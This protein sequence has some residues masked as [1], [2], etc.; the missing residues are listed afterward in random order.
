MKESFLPKITETKP[1]LSREKVEENLQRAIDTGRL[2][3][4]AYWETVKEDSVEHYIEPKKE[5]RISPIGPDEV[6]DPER[7]LAEIK[8]AP[9]EE[10]KQKL[11]EFK[12]KLAYQKE[13]LAR[14][15]EE[16][17][18]TIRENPD[19]IW[20]ELYGKALDLLIKYGADTEEN[21]LKTE[22]VLARYWWR[23]KHIKE[24][25]EQFPDENLLFEAVFGQLPRGK[26]EIMEGPITLYFRC[27]NLKD[28]ALISKQ[29]FLKN[30]GPSFSER[31]S[32]KAEGGVSISTSLVPDLQGTI[33]A[34][35]ARSKFNDNQKKI[36][37]HEEQHA[38]K[39]L[40][41]ERP[42]REMTSYKTGGSLVE[43]LR[44]GRELLAELSVKDEIL[45]YM[46]EG[47]WDANDVF[48]ILTKS[49]KKGGLY[50]Y[51][52][53][54]KSEIMAIHSKGKSRDEKKELIKTV[55]QIFETEYYK[56]IKDGIRSFQDLTDNGYTKEQTIALLNVEPLSKWSKVVKRLTKKQAI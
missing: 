33:I 18:N 52:T 1:Q 31:K 34:E 56:L 12:E 11:Q 37:T 46:K 16:L 40:F 17:T 3:E 30:R 22:K 48:N 55:K 27:H 14:T 39:R 28:Y 38:I 42:V 6:F 10:K 53:K 5:T 23:H 4:Q 45:A 50:D 15:Q 7:E 24:A 19:I 49:G 47:R 13:G 54:E 9:K 36:Y 8:T 2:L 32:A 29:T 21:T 20:K 44:G 51:L 25:R 26:I 35:R 41:N 43:W